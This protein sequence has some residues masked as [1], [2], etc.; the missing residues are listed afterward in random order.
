MH[1]ARQVTWRG[2]GSG[3]SKGGSQPLI[4][5]RNETQ[6]VQNNTNITK[7]KTN[8]KQNKNKKKRTKQKQL[9]K[10]C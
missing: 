5:P 1:T 6:L 7:I 4:P 3:W 8:I 9:K 10:T 2:V